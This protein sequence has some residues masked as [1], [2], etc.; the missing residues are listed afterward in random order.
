MADYCSEWTRISLIFVIHVYMYP[1]MHRK[2]ICIYTFSKLQKKSFCVFLRIYFILMGKG[3]FTICGSFFLI[4]KI[5]KVDQDL[6]KWC[7]L[8]KS[9]YDWRR[10]VALFIRI[11]KQIKC[12]QNCYSWLINAELKKDERREKGSRIKKIKAVRK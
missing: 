8:N 9:D 7:I 2:K 12:K 4:S 10:V 6:I 11:S 5:N 1:T 3:L